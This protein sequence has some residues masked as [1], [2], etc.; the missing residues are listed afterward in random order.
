MGGKI[1]FGRAATRRG[2]LLG[3]LLSWAFLPALGQT[4]PSRPIRVIT[5]GT[6]GT[7]DHV[8]RG[9]LEAAGRLLGQPV[10]LEPKP[11]AN[12]LLAAR[13]VVASP[14]DGYSLLLVTGSALATNPSVY[15]N[16]GYDTER[17]LAPISLIART[18]GVLLVVHPSLPVHT[19]AELVAY[20]RTAKTP[21][22]YSSAG[23]GNAGH[24]MM[25][26]LSRK[27]GIRLTH[28]PYKSATAYTQAV[29]TNE[30]QVAF[31]AGPPA[32]GFLPGGQIRAIGLA[33]P[34]RLPQL[35]S[36]PTLRESGFD[37]ADLIAWVG[38]FAPA[39]TPRDVVAA[40]NK[41]IVEA[42]SNPELRRSMQGLLG[43]EMQ[44]S[45]PDQLAQLLS[46]DLK[47][48]GDAVRVAGI[49]PQ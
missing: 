23:V 32:M 40:L 31:V 34:E 13:A 25:E 10:L 33:G 37:G 5:P 17:D 24:L 1:A 28:V 8:S 48:Y 36:V 9:T 18:T 12:G 14:P 3:T 42:Q 44:S 6:G 2:A 47:R 15:R 41:A 46:V 22:N 16:V 38:L 45:T 43:Y 11:G 27:A 4:F 21:L 7:L 49:T 19:V 39:G 30:V 26:L 29:V 35:P 20:C